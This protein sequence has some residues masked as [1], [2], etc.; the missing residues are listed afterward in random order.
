[1][2]HTEGDSEIQPLMQP[3]VIR[4]IRSRPRLVDFGVRERML[5]Q[6]EENI[7]KRRTTD[8][9]AHRMSSFIANIGKDS[10]EPVLRDVAKSQLDRANQGPLN[11]L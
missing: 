1:M 4:A 2:P 5:E 11:K 7:K 6:L 9:V 10:S 8:T 3:R